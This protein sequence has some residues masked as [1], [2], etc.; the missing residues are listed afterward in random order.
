MTEGDKRAVE[1]ILTASI[2]VRLTVLGGLIIFEGWREWLKLEDQDEP[3][4]AGYSRREVPLK[5]IGREDL[6]RM[7]GYPMLSGE[8]RREAMELITGNRRRGLEL[9]VDG[10]GRIEPP[11]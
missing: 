2:K 11:G 1:E 8:G 5:D 3:L 7:T 4:A 9:E 6:R 10:S